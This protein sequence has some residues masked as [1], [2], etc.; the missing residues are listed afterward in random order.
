MSYLTSRSW[1]LGGKRKAEKLS[2]QASPKMRPPQAMYH[3]EW[4]GWDGW[5]NPEPAQTAAQDLT[6]AA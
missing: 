2:L 5:V 1:Y 3:S 4:L 6:T